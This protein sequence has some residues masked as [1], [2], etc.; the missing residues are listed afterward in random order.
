M[1]EAHKQYSLLDTISDYMNLQENLYTQVPQTR[2]VY[3]S[4][5][6]AG[7]HVVGFS[8]FFIDVFLEVL[9]QAHS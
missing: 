4:A 5:G 3:M 7:R 8:H 6:E 2:L 9:N 1:N